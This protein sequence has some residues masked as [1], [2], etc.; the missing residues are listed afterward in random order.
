MHACMTVVP[1]H[2]PASW[3]GQRSSPALGP[4]ERGD[5]RWSARESTFQGACGSGVRM[6][7]W[8][9][10]ETG[11]L[12]WAQSCREGQSRPTQLHHP[13]HGQD[14]CAGVQTSGSTFSHHQNKE[15]SG[16]EGAGPES[17]GDGWGRGHVW[18]THSGSGPQPATRRP[19]MKAED[20]LKYRNMGGC[21]QR[22][23][24]AVPGAPWDRSC[25]GGRPSP[26]AW[27]C[28]GPGGVS[29]T[30]EG[31][32]PSS[33]PEMSHAAVICEES[34][35]RDSHWLLSRSTWAPCLPHGEN[36]SAQSSKLGESVRSLQ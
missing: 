29:L 24:Q 17:L 25:W 2:P 26:E 15:V 21:C 27:L 20:D 35:A 32:A 30:A 7:T 28:S 3:D 5:C 12:L 36:T 18:V 33:A 1:H 19:L 14:S 8:D 11:R 13:D 9:M 22:L 10:R 34:K 6:K 4:R 16:Y 31:S 23:R